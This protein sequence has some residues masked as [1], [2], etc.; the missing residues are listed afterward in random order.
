M[1]SLITARLFRDTISC[2]MY[3]SFM[4]CC[5]CVRGKWLYFIMIVWHY[6]Y[7][8]DSIPICETSL[9]MFIKQ[10]M[11]MV[12]FS[13]FDDQQSTVCLVI[14][15]VLM[16]LLPNKEEEASILSPHKSQDRQIRPT[17]EVIMGK[18]SSGPSWPVPFY[19]GQDY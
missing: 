13:L 15:I 5:V 16:L 6:I 2:G 10:Y 3:M 17:S 4:M 11:L 1:N 12:R 14:I 8:V 7:I 18:A 19:F 9:S